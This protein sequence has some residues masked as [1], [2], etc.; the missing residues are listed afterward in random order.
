[1]QPK[2]IQNQNG[3]DDS[4]TF[5]HMSADSLEKQR[6]AAGSAGDESP[7]KSE[8]IVDDEEELESVKQLM[9]F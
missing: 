7:A 3:L 8:N 6:Q 4:G 5:D 9:M 2:R 1:M